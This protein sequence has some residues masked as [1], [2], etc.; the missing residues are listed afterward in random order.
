MKLKALCDSYGFVGRYHYKDSIVEVED[1]IKFPEEQ[2]EVVKET[3]AKN[4]S[5]SEV[6]DKAGEIP[7]EPKPKKSK[8]H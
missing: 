2:F 7:V 3:K 5:E 8:K 6:K 1:G 4:E